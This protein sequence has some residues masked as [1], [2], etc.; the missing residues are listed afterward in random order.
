[1]LIESLAESRSFETRL[2]SRVAIVGGGMLGTTLA[3]R[4]RQAGRI[5]TLFEAAERADRRGHASIASR[6]KSLVTMLH[7]LDLAD[8]IRWESAPTFGMRFGALAG[9]R[10]R[11]VDALRERAR[12]IEVD[13][14]LGTP[15]TGIFG[16]GSGFGVRTDAG[17]G[18]FDQVVLA[19]PSPVASQL[20]PALPDRER[21]ALLDVSYIGIITVSFVLER[22][23]QERYI[24]RVRRGRDHFTLLH[25]AAL[26]RAEERQSVIYVS[27]PLGANDRFFEA[28]DRTVIEDFAR[29]VP[30]RARIVSARV[31]RMPHAFAENRQPSFTSSIPGLS[32][33]NAAHMGGGRHHLERTA[34]L[35]TTAFRALCAERLF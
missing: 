12:A 14:R 29:A 20:M 31:M 15:V 32:V 25:P 2:G 9:G 22:Q 19:L 33:V 4:Y 3:L 6:D 5:V 28:D 1:M 24:S 13:V 17:M 35:A 26:S 18:E 16:D 8:S 21:L 7:D 34:A 11:I 27:R 30:G 23:S 10:A